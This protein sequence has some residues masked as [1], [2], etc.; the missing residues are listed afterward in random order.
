[1]PIIPKKA[2]QTNSFTSKVNKFHLL[3]HALTPQTT[4][5]LFGLS[6]ARD[7]G[8]NWKSSRVKSSLLG[9]C[10]PVHLQPCTWKAEVKGSVSSSP[11]WQEGIQFPS[12][13]TP[14][15]RRAR[16]SLRGFACH[17]QRLTA[18]VKQVPLIT[19]ELTST[20]NYEHASM[21]SMTE[22]CRVSTKAILVSLKHTET[23]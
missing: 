13:R 1:M 7:L 5:P 8:T 23:D 15:E 12:H 20:E 11:Q 2:K 10:L 4:S 17:C 14:H 21:C 18:G 6:T 16:S 3:S 22:Y 9:I 19:Q